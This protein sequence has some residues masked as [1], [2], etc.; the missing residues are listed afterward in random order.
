MTFRLFCV[1]LCLLGTESRV[2]KQAMDCTQNACWSTTNPSVGIGTRKLS[3]SAR[4]ARPSFETTKYSSLNPTTW[5]DRT[6]T[7]SCKVFFFFV[8]FFCFVFCVLF[9]V[10]CFFCKPSC[11]KVLIFCF[12]CFYAPYLASVAT[13]LR[14]PLVWC[15]RRYGF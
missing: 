4:C 8:F 10:F 13:A 5:C 6:G 1:S 2:Y 14:R 15:C 9:F 11:C 12:F 7:V 3:S